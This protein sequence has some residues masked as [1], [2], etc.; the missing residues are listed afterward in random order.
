[1]EFLRLLEGVRTPFFDTFFSTVTHLGEETLFLAIAIFVF[2]CIGKR[3][4]YYL[5]CVGFV[6]RPPVAK[7]VFWNERHL[8]CQAE[9]IAKLTEEICAVCKP[10]SVTALGTRGNAAVGLY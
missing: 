8:T 6:S 5:L 9:E 2:W 7:C 10:V 4:G 1:M 3:E